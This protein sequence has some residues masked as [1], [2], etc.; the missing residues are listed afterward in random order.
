MLKKKVLLIKKSLNKIL[1]QYKNI[2]KSVSKNKLR[3]KLK[4]ITTNVCDELITKI[5]EF[6]MQLMNVIVI[7]DDFI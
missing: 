1:F 6:K 7:N 4:K 5:D 2:K 3:L